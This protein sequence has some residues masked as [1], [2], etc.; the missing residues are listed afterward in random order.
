[1]AIASVPQGIRGSNHRHGCLGVSGTYCLPHGR[2]YADQKHGEEKIFVWADAMGK[3]LFE[4]SHENS[5]LEG[6][7]FFFPMGSRSNSK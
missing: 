7:E 1:V 2:Q 3:M 6:P 5:G 4:F